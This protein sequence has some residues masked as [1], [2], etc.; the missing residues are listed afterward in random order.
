[1]IVLFLGRDSL[2][3]YVKYVRWRRGPKENE[4]KKGLR[5]KILWVVKDYSNFYINPRFVTHVHCQFFG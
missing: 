3:E 1:M 2:V 5:G 4:R